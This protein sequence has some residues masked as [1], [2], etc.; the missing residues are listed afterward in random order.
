MK[1][2]KK[3]TYIF[4]A[5]ALIA[6]II[7]QLKNNKRIAQDRVYHFDKDQPIHVQA[8]TLS[9]DGL[10]HQISY[11]GTF[12]PQKETRISA[13]IQGLVT[14]VLVDNGSRVSAGQALIQ[15]DN[16]LLKLQLE[17][18]KLQIEGLE[19][20][21]KRYQILAAADAIQGVQLEKAELGLK[22]ALVQKATL[23][24]QIRKTTIR[25]PFS[26]IITAK[27]T[28]EGAFAAPGVPLLQLTDISTLK[29]TISITDAELSHFIP[30]QKFSVLADA[31][32]DK[33]LT[34]MVTLSASKANIG[35]SFPVELSVENTPDQMIRSGMFGKVLRLNNPDDQLITIPASS[36]VGTNI[37]PQVYKIIGNKAMLNDI[38]ISNRFG[39]KI[40]VSRGLTAGDVII[41]GGFVNLF[42]GANVLYN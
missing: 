6:I 12:E 25:A 41:T 18:V 24:E 22:S 39:D 30:G 42:D 11:A 15:L 1:N 23:E 26:G 9:R 10:E 29:F 3:I 14:D 28:E 21:V 16:A 17:T 19:S 5:I 33:V 2:I 35:N 34:G 13:D 36:V 7:L 8:M 38:T 37:K 32:P 27:L 4:V 31:F 20:D 40:L